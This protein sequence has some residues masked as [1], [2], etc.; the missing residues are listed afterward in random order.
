MDSGGRQIWSY[1]AG[2]GAGFS[3]GSG[4]VATWSG[5]IFSILS[6]DEGVTLFSDS[7]QGGI[8]DARVGTVYAAI[9]TGTEHDST[10]LVLDSTGRQV[11]SIELKNLTVLDFGF[12]NNDTLLWVMS[13]NTEGTVPLCTI[14]NYRPGKMRLSDISDNQQVLYEVVFQ[15][16][17]IRAVGTTHIKDYDY[18]NR[19][20]EDN[21]IQVYGW[22]LM[23]IDEEAA[24]PMMAFVPLDQS[25]GSTGISD[26][27]MIRGQID[28][29]IHLPYPASRV[30]A[31]DDAI[32]AFTSQ[33]VMVCHMGEKTPTTYILPIYVDG[34]LGMT[35]NKTCVA[36]SGGSV[37]L[38]PLP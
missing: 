6:A 16:A 13:L 30:V 33:Y 14:S 10:I 28:Q 26:V 2:S 15:S 32:Y 22:Y 8:L 21:R 19:E 23:S 20:I 37:Y 36:T 3:V 17:Q 34:V 7:V 29:A 11:D 1:A 24:N 25:D 12:Y 5:G 18:N 38:I 31:V 27:R 4:G 9:Q 35:E